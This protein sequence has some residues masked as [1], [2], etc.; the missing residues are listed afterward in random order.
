MPV[1]LGAL[2]RPRSAAIFGGDPSA[3]GRVL[4]FLVTDLLGPGDDGV[5]LDLTKSVSVSSRVEVARNPVERVV[6]TSIRKQ[7]ETIT[8]QGSLSATPLGLFA[9]ATGAFGSLV[10]RDLSEVEKLRTLQER[11]EPLILVT[12]VWIF[13]SVALEDLTE[14]HPGS[15]KVDVTL[16]FKRIEIVSPLTVA[17]TAALDALLSAPVGTNDVGLQATET[18]PDPGGPG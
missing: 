2:L 4:A 7:P 16:R 9:S 12:T 15:N 13:T 10:R 14:T 5:R 8:V 17:G 11:G 1:D 6:A 3:V 18:I